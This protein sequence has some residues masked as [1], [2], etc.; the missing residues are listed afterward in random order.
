MVGCHKV[1]LGGAHHLGRMADNANST[2]RVRVEV[3]IMA[4]VRQLSPATAE[5]DL[6]VVVRLV[7]DHCD[8]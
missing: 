1:I 2:L 8:C 3:M 7:R 5:K 6:R 4:R